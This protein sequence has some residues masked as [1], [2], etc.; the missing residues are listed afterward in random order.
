MPSIQFEWSILSFSFQFVF[1]IKNAIVLNYI[2]SIVWYPF[3]LKIDVMPF[4]S[5]FPVNQHVITSNVQL[6]TC[7]KAE[8]TFDEATWNVVN[9][10]V[11]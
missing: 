8:E 6:I 5:G 10:W 11:S 7:N 1:I 2:F 9:K 3:V 4:L